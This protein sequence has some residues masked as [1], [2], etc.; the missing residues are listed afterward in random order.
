MVGRRWMG[1][2]RRGREWLRG[3]ET[4]GRSGRVTRSPGAEGAS[5][6]EAVAEFVAFCGFAISVPVEVGYVLFEVVGHNY[7]IA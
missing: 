6:V 3:G 1:Y 7:D 2:L 4:P 5:V